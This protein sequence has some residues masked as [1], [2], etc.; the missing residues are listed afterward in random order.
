MDSYTILGVKPGASAAEIKRAY[1]RLAMAWHPDRNDHPEATERF[2]AIRAA[3]DALLAKSETD[4]LEEPEDTAAPSSQP[5]PPRAAD[6]RLDLEISLEEGAGGC[7]KSIRYQRGRPCATC[8]GT[9]EAG[10]SR[11]RMCGACHGSGRVRH[12]RQGLERCDRCDGRGFLSERIC[13]D[14]EGSGR[15][16]ADVS[17]SLKVPQGMLTGD[18]LR[19]AGQGE[20]GSGDLG[21]GDL[22]L[23]IRIVPHPVFRQVGRNLH[24]RVPVSVLTLL[25][26][27]EVRIP[28]LTGHE[29]LLVEAGSVESRS[30]CFAG[31]GYPGRNGTPTGDLIVAMEP[32]WPRALS[33]RERELVLRAQ[34]LLDARLSES[35]PEIAAW[36]ERAGV[37][38]GSD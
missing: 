20:P 8:A 15:E 21:P 32:V 37:A 30:H 3:Y 7:R 9:G 36:R 38:G 26:G 18:E 16:E 23:T 17:L 11:S 25:G 10:I 22:F 5:E 19:L 27:G 29:T 28:K 4:V 6:I 2:K 12:R 14:C 24:L 33:A 1:R 31:L 13:P 35:F 34:T